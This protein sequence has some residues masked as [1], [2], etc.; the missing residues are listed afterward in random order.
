MKKL[1][2]VAEYCLLFLSLLFVCLLSLYL[3]CALPKKGKIV[4]F[5]HMGGGWEKIVGGIKSNVS[6]RLFAFA[7]SHFTQLACN[8]IMI[9][10]VSRRVCHHDHVLHAGSLLFTKSLFNY[11]VFFRVCLQLSVA[12]R[13]E[14]GSV[15]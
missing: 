5:I 14:D 9:C 1:I 13:N 12:R 6:V 10:G 4:N 7:V 3:L 15:L 2:L 11:S 8:G